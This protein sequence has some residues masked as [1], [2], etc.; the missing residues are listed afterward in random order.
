MSFSKYL[1]HRYEKGVI[2]LAVMLYHHGL[3]GYKISEILFKKFRI[4]VSA[5]TICKWF[6]KFNSDKIRLSYMPRNRYSK[7]WHADEMYLKAKGRWF[8]LLVVIDDKNHILGLHISPFRNVNSAVVVLK[9][10]K[11]LAG[12]PEIIVTDGWYGYSRAI[13]RVFGWKSGVRHVRAHFKTEIV[14][15]N[16]KLY[17]LSNNRIEGWNSW[18]RHIYRRMRGFKSLL[19]MRQFL[20]TFKMLYNLRDNAWQYLLT[21]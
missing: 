12:V 1:R 2:Q 13:K 11:E 16:N 7:I 15:H 3:S 8:Y 19:S 10:A 4:K 18:F 9:K 17:L 6:R 21:L 5:W 20:K 14:I